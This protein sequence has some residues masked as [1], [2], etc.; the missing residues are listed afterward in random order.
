[1]YFLKK[2]NQLFNRN[3]Q[4]KF[5][6]LHYSID[7]AGIELTLRIPVH[8]RKYLTVNS[9]S[10]VRSRFVFEREIGEVII[11]SNSFIGG[12]TIIC[13]DKVEIGNDVLISWGCTIVDND[14][15]S[16][17]WDL[18]KDDISDWKKG[19]DDGKIGKYK[20]WENVKAS[21][22]RI[23]DKVWIGFNSIILKGVKIGKGSV[24]GA[25]S[26]VT[27]DVP[28]NTLVAGNPAKI[29]KELE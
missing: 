6:N 2:L 22:I 25:G 18:R 21:P 19:F 28:P 29:I 16:I 14:S 12:S 10:I 15:H 11:G 9:N 3:D 17:Y 24:V 20:N 7:P 4:L 26:V 23:E 13:V 27:K 8:G 5:M 1:M